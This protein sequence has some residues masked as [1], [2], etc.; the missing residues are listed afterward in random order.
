MD[1]PTPP[2]FAH[3]LIADTASRVRFPV[4]RLAVQI[5]EELRDSDH[6]HPLIHGE[7]LAGRAVDELWHEEGLGSAYERALAEVHEEYVTRAARVLEVADDLLKAGRESWIARALRH[8][9]A[10]D[11]SWEAQDRL[12]FLTRFDDDALCATCGA[13]LGTRGPDDEASA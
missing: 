12:G 3:R 9:F 2:D 1:P 8:Q 13:T 6:W 5:A 10:F 11:T 7:E 4:E